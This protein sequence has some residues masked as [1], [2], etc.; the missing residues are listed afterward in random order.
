[1]SNHRNIFS[2]KTVRVY[3]QLFSSLFCLILPLRQCQSFL[4]CMF[5]LIPIRLLLH[6]LGL[7]VCVGESD[8]MYVC[9]CVSVC[10][11]II[12]AT[13]TLLIDLAFSFFEIIINPDKRKSFDH[14]HVHL[15]RYIDT[16]IYIYIQIYRTHRNI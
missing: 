9:E 16:D 8:W 7:C 2:F 12:W 14:V 13:Q 6:K 10:V 11:Y 15:S 5:T 3:L 4:E 1:M